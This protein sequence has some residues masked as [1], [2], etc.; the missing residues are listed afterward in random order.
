LCSADLKATTNL[1]IN[2]KTTLDQ[3]LI[4]NKTDSHLDVSEQL[5]A[6]EI[7]IVADFLIA[8]II[9]IISF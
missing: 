7:Q 5:S 2:K 6:Q 4:N 8:F 3:D 1:T 9:I